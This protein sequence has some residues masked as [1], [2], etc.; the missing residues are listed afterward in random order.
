MMHHIKNY[1]KTKQIYRPRLKITKTAVDDFQIYNYHLF[2]KFTNYLF[3]ATAFILP[4]LFDLIRIYVVKDEKLRVIFIGFNIC[5]YL[6]SFIY[7]LVK[8]NKKFISSGAW[9]F[10][11]FMLCQMVSTLVSALIFSANSAIFFEKVNDKVQLTPLGYATTT[12][13]QA[14]VGLLTVVL[15]LFLSKDLRM[16]IFKTIR[17]NFLLLA[18]VTIITLFVAWQIEMIFNSIK[19]LIIGNNVS[20]NQAELIKNL[21]SDFGKVSLFLMVVLTAPIFEELATKQSIFMLSGSKIGGFVITT[22]LFAWMHVSNSGD[23]ENIFSYLGFSL[24]LSAVF[25]FSR[26]N[27]TYSFLV[28]LMHNL[29]AYVL[30]VG[31]S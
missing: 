14:I 11:L 28:H 15:I 18:L 29:I 12:L 1:L 19:E 26:E 23:I 17:Y 8:E 6:S 13:T 10:Y 24:V 27:I 30:L 31:F 20:S 2:S 5:S 4:V 22:F 3:I 21:N 25:V 16:K 7:I 9:A